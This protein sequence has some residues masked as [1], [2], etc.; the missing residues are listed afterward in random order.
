MRCVTFALLFAV[1]CASRAPVEAPGMGVNEALTGEVVTQPCAWPIGATYR[2]TYE[3]RYE[4]W[5]GMTRYGITTVAPVELSLSANDRFI[6]DIGPAELIGAPRDLEQASRLI[7][8]PD[9]VAFKLVVHDM[10]L[11]SIENYPEVMNELGILLLEFVSLW[12]SPEE[13]ESTLSRHEDPQEGMQHLLSVPRSLLMM[14]CVS[15]SDG[16]R[17][18][19][20]EEGP[21]PL[22]GPHNLRYIHT[23]EATIRP[24]EGT[25]TYLYELATD[26]ESLRAPIEHYVSTLPEDSKSSVEEMM[27]DYAGVEF[28]L[29]I[30]AVH[31]LVDGMPLFVEST[32]SQRSQ[33]GEVERS[34]VWRWTRVPEP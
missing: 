29:K 9:P 20:F 16:Q 4:D 8:S 27:T 28:V 7:T 2:Y 23:T 32:R 12:T 26:P 24:E 17:V 30:V 33:F 18:V 11:V 19:T 31:S 6:F 10:G 22:G 21:H 15:L 1:A 14:R 13:I 34:G 5:M 25:A 3:R